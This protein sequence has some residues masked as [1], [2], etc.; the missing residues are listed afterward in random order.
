[1][2]DEICE[3]LPD[4]PKTELAAELLGVPPAAVV[5]H[6]V[7]LWLWALQHAKDGD[8]SA[9]T[10]AWIAKAARWKGDPETFVNALT[11]CAHKRNGHGFL[12]D[13]G[14]GGLI[15]HDWSD[16]GGKLHMAKAKEAKRKADE[17]AAQRESARLAALGQPDNSP[18]RPPDVQ[19]NHPDIPEVSANVHGRLPDKT[20]RPEDVQTNGADVPRMSANVHPKQNRTEQDKEKLSEAKNNNAPARARAAPDTVADVVALLASLGVA[21][22]KAAAL[23]VEHTEQEIRD[24]IAWQQLRPK[25][26]NPAGALIA[27]IKG[28]YKAPPG[29]Q[30]QAERDEADAVFRSQQAEKEALKA[31]LDELINDLSPEDRAQIE[32]EALGKINS[33]QRPPQGVARAA[34]LAT[35]RRKIAAHR[36]HIEASILD[37]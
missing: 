36:Y 10:P 8:L 17:R 11:Q 26:D 23:C 31:Q 9:F 19:P 25:A 34:V 27:A 2:Y 33:L 21:P 35:T 20:G 15:I 5:G 29:A 7:C 14:D 28:R 6:L 1:M 30:K 18:G 32:Q 22:D 4:H 37:A 13:D 24:Q 3:T 12:E 16:Y